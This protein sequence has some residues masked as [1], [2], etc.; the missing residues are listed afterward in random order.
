MRKTSLL[1]FALTLLMFTASAFAQYTGVVS[2]DTIEAEPG[3]SFQVAVRLSDNNL[4]F[5]G[6]TIPLH[7]ESDHLFVDS[8]SFVGSILPEDFAGVVFV[9]PAEGK[10]RITYLPRL[11]GQISTPTMEPVGGVLGTIFFRLDQAAAP[12]VIELD[13]INVETI[14]EPDIPFWERV[15][16]TDG[17]GLI[18]VL[19]GFVP[20]AV[21]VQI[22]T[23]VNDGDKGGL[24][25][26]FALAQNYPNPFNPVTTIEYALPA[27]GHVELKVFN[28]L[29]QTVSTLV[30]GYE[31]AGTHRVEFDAGSLPSGIYFYRISHA[32]GSQTRKMA[33]VK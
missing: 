29:G 4:A 24:P 18:T 12:G 8:V 9:E 2:V 33:L 23:G 25:Q 15:E 6:I 17:S 26:A 16:V 22:P 11:D 7:Y 21:K 19:P 14:I 30:D 10:V 5:S 31:T 13:S 3:E 32:E 20:G 28:V 1:A 27:S